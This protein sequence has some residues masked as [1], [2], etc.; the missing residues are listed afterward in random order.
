MHAA[1][2]SR[3]HIKFFRAMKQ[4][5]YLQACLMHQFVALVRSR[6]LQRWVKLTNDAIP[7]AIPLEQFANE[8]CF[9]ST[10]SRVLEG[11]AEAAQG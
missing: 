7:Q 11:V 2:H 6:V 1:F 5:T 8:C 4:A 10:V 9:A 3:N